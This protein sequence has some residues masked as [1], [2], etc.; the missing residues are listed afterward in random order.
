MGL[1]VLFVGILLPLRGMQLTGSLPIR[2]AMV[3]MV[4]LIGHRLKQTLN[5]QCQPLFHGIGGP[6]TK[7]FIFARANKY[8]L[9]SVIPTNVPDLN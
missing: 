5:L 2:V 8:V 6:K 1:K 3:C 9:F 7:N 4:L